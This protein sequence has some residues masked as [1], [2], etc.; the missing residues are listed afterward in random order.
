M[1][2][3]ISLRPDPG[4]LLQAESRSWHRAIAASA[5]GVAQRGD[6]AKI[7]KQA[8]PHDER[9]AVILRGAV[10]PTPV[11][12]FPAL[13]IAE[14]FRSLAPGS[15]ALALFERGLK[16]DLTGL[17][18]IR[19]PNIASWPAQPVFVAEGAPGPS[20]QWRF[21]GAVV[22]PTR[23]ILVLAA[24]SRELEDATPETAS[25]VIGRVLA[26]ATNKSIDMVAFG[27]APA[28]AVQPSGLLYGVPPIPASPA[29]SDAMADDLG[30]LVGAIGD[31]SVDP[32]GAVFVCSPREATIIKTRV[33]PKFDSPVLSTLGLPAKTVACFAPAAVASGYQEAPQIE[34][35][36]QAVYHAEGTSPAEIVDTGGALAAPTLSTF[37]TDVISIKVRGSAAWA[38]APG[39]AQVV[40][41]VNW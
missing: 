35:S 14:A 20:V 24:T 5:L 36:H 32:T 10:G 6:P 39:G 28:D 25:A 4:G 8:W 33:G 2:R 19:V 1:T 37:Q 29:G 15:A 31:A 41:D 7:L 38:V 11:P 3:P 12:D 23:K 13:N 22:G 26:D 17:N 21:G 30:N 34:T 18:S 40:N 16:L 9:A 27:T